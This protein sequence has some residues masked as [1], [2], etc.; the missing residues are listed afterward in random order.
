MTNA[1][2][3]RPLQQNIARRRTQIAAHGTEVS[4]ILGAHH[5]FGRHAEQR[6]LILGIGGASVGRGV[7]EDGVFPAVHD[8]TVRAVV[9][10]TLRAINIETRKNGYERAKLPR[11]FPG[12]AVRCFIEHLNANR[13][14]H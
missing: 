8:G 10:V 5:G 13:K 12:R 9:H 7:Y 1:V 2:C 4:R 14:H 3:A 11:C 6:Q